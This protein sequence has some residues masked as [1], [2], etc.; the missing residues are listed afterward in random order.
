M[1]TAQRFQL[2]VKKTV[3]SRMV[4]STTSTKNAVNC[5]ASGGTIVSTVSF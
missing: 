4:K 2:S 3:K 5:G 1:E